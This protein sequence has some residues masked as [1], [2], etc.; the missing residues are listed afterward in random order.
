MNIYIC[1]S[2]EMYTCM[3]YAYNRIKTRKACTSRSG[4]VFIAQGVGV[5]D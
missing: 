2:K 4:K 1:I 3:Q 5:L